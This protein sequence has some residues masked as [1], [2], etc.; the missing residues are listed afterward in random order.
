MSED[1]LAKRKELDDMVCE[2]KKYAELEGTELGEA[3]ELIIT[4]YGYGDYVSEEFEK[5]VIEEI[6]YQLQNFKDHCKIVEGEITTTHIT[7]DLEWD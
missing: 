4:L 7:K 1:L 3:C 6:K 2:L 5:S